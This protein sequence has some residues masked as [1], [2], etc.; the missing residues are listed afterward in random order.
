MSIANFE[1]GGSPIQSDFDVVVVGSGAAAL[2]A[3]VTAAHEGL[4]VLVV[5]KA[6]QFGG[7]GA[8]SGGVAWVP[9]NPHIDE[10]GKESGEFDSRD[11]AMRYFKSL[12]GPDRMRPAL[13]E[14][15]YANGRRMVE[16][17]E[18]R[19]EVQF[20]R[21]TYPDYKAHLDGGMPVGRSIAAK[22]YD[23]RLLGEWFDRLKPPMKE[24]CMQGSMMVDGMDVFHLM[25]LMNMGRSLS[26]LSSA[27]H[28]LK[29]FLP[30]VRDRIVHGRG[31]RLTI[32]N[33]LI[34]RL[35]KSALNAGVTLWPSSPARRVVMSDGRVTGIVVERDGKELTLHVRRAVVLGSGGFSHDEALKRKLIPFPDQHQT[36]CPETNSGDGLHMGMATGGRM[37]DGDRTFHNYLGS[38]VSMMRDRSGRVI[39]KIP[40]LRRDRNKPGFV[41]VNRRGLRFVNEAWPYNDVAHAMDT[42]PDA[43]PAFLICDHTRLRKYGLGLV[44][45]GPAWARPL[46][47]YLESGH[48]VKAPTLAELAKK[49]GIDAN[50]LEQTVA[51]MNEYARTGKDLE[52]HKGET[53]YDRWQGDPAVTPNPSLGPVETAP[54]YAITLWPGDMGTFCGLVTDERARVLDAG[55][56]PIPGL[57]AVGCDMHPVFTGSYPGG[58][59]SIG[60]GMTFGFIAGQDVARERAPASVPAAHV[61]S[62]QAA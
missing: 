17:L 19:T 16:F 38:Q 24:L 9:N 4:K 57:Y 18:S 53:A 2:T 47:R 27:R 54:F 12:V 26:A 14:A 13:M 8:L 60:P 10:T 43:V 20:E 59:G 50:A 36:I 30:F 52:F 21:T 62:A 1:R 31:T 11:R 46:G 44:R 45:P 55:E 39:S 7:T 34:A 42:T 49:L 41:L 56:H 22:E 3:A 33:A 28:V 15:L 58:G 23:G 25:N 48:L 61:E 51:K 37:G 32:G 5:E 29:R 40:F 6:S 35:M